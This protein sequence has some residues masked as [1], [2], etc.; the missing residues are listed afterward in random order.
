LFAAA[1]QQLPDLSGAIET[2]NPAP[3]LQWL[4]QRI[5]QY[6]RTFTSEEL[7]LQASGKVLDVQYFLRY[8]LDKYSNIYDF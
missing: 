2:G 3:L 5:H 7:C 4:R 6:G 8:L 1:R